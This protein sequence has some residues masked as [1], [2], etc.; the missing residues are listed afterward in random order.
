MSMQS[1][2]VVIGGGVHGV[3]VTYFLA[4]AGVGKVTLLEK[5]RLA[6]G[7][8]GRSGAMVRPL[9]FV[10]AYL[11]LVLESTRVFEQ[12]GD[13]IGGDAGFIQNG[14]L[15]ITRSLKIEDFGGDI[16]LMREHGAP[17]EVLDHAALPQYA[18]TARFKEDE[19]GVF[20]PRGGLAD[21]VRTTRTLGDA[22]RRAG[23]D[24]REGVG[25][26]GIRVSNGRIEA[27]DTTDG[28]IHTRLVVNCGGAWSHRVAALAGVT[29]PITPHRQPT[30]M[31]SSREIVGPESP[32]WSD[33][34]NRLYFCQ[35]GASVIR[36][37]LFGWTNDPVDPDQY[38]ETIH[39]QRIGLV[40]QALAA[41]TDHE[42]EMTGYGGFSALYDMT[43]DG[44][45]IIGQTE[46]VAG[47]WH[48]CGWSG[49]GFAS[50][51][52]AGRCIADMIVRG[53]SDIDL[54]MFRWPRSNGVAKM[55]Y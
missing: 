50:A 31:F 39:P 12:W 4:R 49:N 22:A 35:L 1:D 5:K 26:T 47:L 15:R 45:P 55:R 53:T 23:A 27:V 51:P 44:H 40:R 10:P 24:I 30:C 48:N 16:E 14:F 2:I 52:A 18:P 41:R 13:I 9:F 11:Q 34:V 19:I 38:D 29:L 7:P 8:T 25:V 3:G 20:F 21:A 37:A 54:S 28:P 6:S 46:E 42:R 32:I 33:G 17:F 36:A 43:P